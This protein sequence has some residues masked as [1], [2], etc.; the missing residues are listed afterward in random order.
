MAKR[1]G[2]LKGGCLGCLGLL[3]LFFIFVGANALLVMN[4]SGDERIQ[5]VVLDS[6]TSLAPIPPARPE[7]ADHPEGRPAAGR[8]WLILELGQGEF[9]VHP[10]EP[11][12]GVVI[13]SS[14]DA[15]IYELQEFHQTWPDSAWVYQVGFHRTITGMQ[16]VLREIMGGNHGAKL[17]VFIPPDLPIELNILVREGGLVA[18]LGGLWLTGLDLRYDKGGISLSVDEPLREP[19]PSISIHGRMGGGDVQGLGNA[20]PSVL[21]V[22]C[23]MGGMSLDLG[24]AW[25]GDCDARLSLTMGGLDVIVPDNLGYESAGTSE[26]GFTRTDGEVPLPML[27]VQQQVKMGEIKIR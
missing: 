8:G 22:S 11:G 16:A 7:A 2:C 3:V 27:R 25:Q 18:K 10:G 9:E 14:Y 5:D 17:H 1:M 21:D 20:S 19:V 15:S 23:R 4:R 26:G 24:G 12:S 13:R 6:S